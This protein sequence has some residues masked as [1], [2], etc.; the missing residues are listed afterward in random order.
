ML[1]AI[2][3][4]LL[5]SLLIVLFVPACNPTLVKKIGL[6]SSFL[7][8]W[9]TILCW[10]SHVPNSYFQSND[11][12]YWVDTATS[13]LKWG[14]VQFGLDE[15]STPF[16]LLTALL[17]P[18]CI[19][20]S[21]TTVRHLV[22]EFVFCLLAIHLLLIGVFTSLNVLV[23]YILFE[24]ILIP[25]FIIIGVWGSRKER[26][27]AAYYFFFFTLAGSLLMLLSIFVL[28]V[29]TGTLDYQLLVDT[30][31]PPSIQ[32][33]CFLGFFFSLAV[34][35]PK[36]PFHIWLPQAHVEAPV[37]GSV[38][39][40]GILLKLGG[41]G[42]IRFSWG[43]FPDASQYFSPMIMTLSALAVIYASLS[44]CRQTDA[45]RLV[46]YSSVA[47]MGIVTIG[48]F[49]KTI[50]GI[51]AAVILMIAHG[52][53][54]SGLFIMVTNLYD[55]FHTKL[56]RYY[57]GATYTMPIFSL[58]FFALILANI[59]FPISL[60]FIGEFFSIVSAI[61]FSWVAIVG[62]LFGIVLSAA[63]SLAFYNKVVFGHPS[64]FTLV[65]R[66]L[67]RREF[68]SPILLIALTVVL[69]L[70]PVSIMASYASPFLI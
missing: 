54:S 24:V 30:N 41:Y 35:V 27:R 5:L 3:F 46:A 62:P 32:I 65:T 56:I 64:Q 36:I 15:I 26:E 2:V 50:E 25:M 6:F 49:S 67:T 51:M 10:G 17:T 61:Q 7:V 22:R 70:A 66:D 55:R 33:W 19:I 60:N 16:V 14:P 40:A 37:A 18:V 29:V 8:L 48:I 45:K 39:L 12:A 44:T 43:L 23:F 69:G 57:R 63:Y 20:V 11:L 52:L 31:I 9:L 34:K 4:V 1:L 68:V 59:A 42:F 53:V 21:W 58:L 38:I 13:S 47:H 28:Y